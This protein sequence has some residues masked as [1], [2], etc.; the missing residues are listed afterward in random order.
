MHLAM[1][2]TAQWDNELVADLAPKC[3]MLGEPQVMRIRRL[4]STN[5]AWL[6]G[7]EFAVGLVPKPARLG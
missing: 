1:M 4:A 6:R 3:P 5:Q 7:D 2:A